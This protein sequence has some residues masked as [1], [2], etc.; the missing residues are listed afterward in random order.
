MSSSSTSPVTH[1]PVAIQ[2]TR[3]GSLS[4]GAQQFPYNPPGPPQ[5]APFQ[6]FA[7]Q[8]RRSTSRERLTPIS[9]GPQHPELP[10]LKP[11]FGV[12]LEDLYRRDGTAIPMTVYQC[13]QAVELFG[14]NVEGIYRLS[15]NASHIAQMKAVFD[16]GMFV[17]EQRFL[18]CWPLT[19]VCR[20]ISG[21]FHQPGEFPP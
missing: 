16:N 1:A 11:V 6:Q 13:I 8:A 17:L 2:Q 5:P 19:S 4:G 12:S 7:A 14:L 3:R 20:F 15:G 9:S 18:Y 21:G 10:P